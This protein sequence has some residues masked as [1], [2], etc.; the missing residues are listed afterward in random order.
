M[1]HSL[2]G[3]KGLDTAEYERDAWNRQP[4]PFTHCW[5]LGGLCFSFLKLLLPLNSCSVSCVLPSAT[6]F[7][8]LPLININREQLAFLQYRR[9]A[10]VY[11]R[12]VLQFWGHRGQMRWKCQSLSH[13][14][15][16]ATPWTVPC[17]APLSMEFSKQEYWSGLPF[18]S[19]E[20]LPN[21]E[22]ETC[23]PAL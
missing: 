18:P 19:P 13:F 3:R 6:G 23:F 17:Q 21:P 8:H 11:Y 14:Q 22:I 16:F 12:V 15:L 4:C 10:P 9:R 2:W 7:F 1:G 20:D 5:R